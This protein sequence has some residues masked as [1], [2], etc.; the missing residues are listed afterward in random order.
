MEHH[1]SSGLPCNLAGV[2]L[3]MGSGRRESN[4]A[5]EQSVQAQ[6][7]SA[8]LESGVTSG[9]EEVIEFGL[10]LQVREIQESA[11][12]KGGNMAFGFGKIT[13]AAA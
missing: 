9:L 1:F 10:H 8:Q 5:H 12:S 11:L 7:K 3:R 6:D 4:R 2:C 13:Q